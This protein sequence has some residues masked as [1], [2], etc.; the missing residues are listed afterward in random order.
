MFYHLVSIAGAG[1][2]LRF[3][4]LHFMNLLQHTC[5]RTQSHP[6]SRTCLGT[7]RVYAHTHTHTHTHTYTHTHTHTHT[8]TQAGTSIFTHRHTSHGHTQTCPNAHTYMHTQIHPLSPGASQTK[9]LPSDFHTPASRFYGQII[10]SC[11]AESPPL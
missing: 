6:H 2:L 9:A 1:V 11:K 10:I 7:Y 4:C 5:V 3:I 8:H